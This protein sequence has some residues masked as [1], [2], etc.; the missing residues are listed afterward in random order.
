MGQ[1]SFPPPGGVRHPYLLEVET[2]FGII[3][4]VACTASL[5]KT[6][7]LPNQSQPSVKGSPGTIH[8]CRTCQIRTEACV[9]RNK[10]RPRSATSIAQFTVWFLQAACLWCRHV[11]K[12]VCFDEDT[13]VSTFC[14]ELLRCQRQHV[15]F[16]A[17]G[18]AFSIIPSALRTREISGDAVGEVREVADMHE[19]SIALRD[20]VSND[21]HTHMFIQC[22]G[23]HLL[24][25][26]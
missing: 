11:M 17:W 26:H 1:L 25:T 10:K 4:V 20:D 9:E 22:A 7:K 13:S 6:L 5:I 2:A 16:F 15:L 19:V 23:T 8:M 12:S 21:V 14:F 18:L 24:T 3:I